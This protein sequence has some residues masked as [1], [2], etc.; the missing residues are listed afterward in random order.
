L[1]YHKLRKFRVVRFINIVYLC[2]CKKETMMEHIDY[3]RIAEAIEYLSKNFQQQPDLNEVAQQ[4][5]LSP[6]HFQRI[7]SDWVGVSPKKFMQYLSIEHL[8]ANIYDLKN[9][10]QAADLVGLS[11]PSRVYDLFVNIEGVTPNE[12]KTFG[13]NLVIHYGFHQTPFGECLIANTGKGVCYMAFIDEHNRQTEFN[14]FEQKWQLAQRVFD[15]NATQQIVNQIFSKNK[16]SKVN[17]LLQGTNFQLNVWE[18]LLKIPSGAV[19]TYQKIAESIENPNA[20]RAV[21][22]AIGNNPIAY[23]IPCHRVIRKEGVVGEYHW[24]STRKKA[25]LGMEMSGN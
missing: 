16:K 10:N 19:S 3:Q 14:R 11:T 25:I 6:F 8:R 17:V 1:S 9:L 22:T 2:R 24:G 23:L 5:H 7:F 12:Y 15:N 18:A 13:K 4:V 21:G 20:T